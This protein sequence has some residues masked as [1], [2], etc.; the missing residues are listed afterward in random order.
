M[1]YIRMD[2]IELYKNAFKSVFSVEDEKLD[3]TFSKNS[4]DNWDSLRQLC[5][6]T[7]I[8]EAFGVMFDPEDIISLDSYQEGMNIL[9]K[10]NIEF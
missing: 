6:V 1:K 8:E 4:V 10:Y 3:E 5:L 2:N 7:S 9:K